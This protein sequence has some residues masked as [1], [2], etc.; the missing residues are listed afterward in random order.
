MTADVT[1]IPS[2]DGQVKKV[3][4]KESDGAVHNFYK[5]HVYREGDW[6]MVETVLG[7]SWFFQPRAVSFE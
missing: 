4:V 2:G 6:V 7:Q 3:Q 1:W 5:A